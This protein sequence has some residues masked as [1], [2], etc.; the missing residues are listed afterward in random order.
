MYIITFKSLV[1]PM[2]FTVLCLLG[3]WENPG[4]ERSRNFPIVSQRG[5]PVE[6]WLGGV[7]AGTPAKEGEE[8]RD[9]LF[10]PGVDPALTVHHSQV[11]PG[12]LCVCVCVC[13]TRL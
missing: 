2:N 4:V 1:N 5:S 13:N 8:N 11:F 7:L 3:G 12:T 10:R 6:V 9:K